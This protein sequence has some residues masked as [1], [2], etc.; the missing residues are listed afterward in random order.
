MPDAMRSRAGRYVAACA[1]TVALAVPAAGQTTIFNSNGYEPGAT[2]YTPGNVVGQRGFQGQP[3]SGTAGSIQTAT[4]ASG[5]QAFQIAGPALV[6][7]TTF[8]GGNFWF[9]PTDYNPV[10]SATPHVIV[11]FKSFTPAGIALPTDIPFAGVY[12]EGF[13]SFGLQQAVSPIMVNANGGVTVF[14]T[15]A[16]GGPNKAVSTASS[17]LPRGSWNELIADF[18]FATQTFRV[19]RNGDT[20]PLQFTTNGS[21]QPITP[22][23]DIPFRNGDANLTTDRVAEFGMLGFYGADTSGAPVQ[24]LN[25]FFIDDFSVTAS[26]TAF[27]PVPEPGLLLA[28]GA[29]GLTGWRTYRR[30]KAAIA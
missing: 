12:I 13:N 21:G 22:L 2:G 15:T 7:N 28:V 24:P 5:T 6:N 18:N 27:N 20:N 14:T 26:A 3:T 1:L 16:T 8:G 11:D 4:V 29:V 10:A 19:Y 30:R 25:N 9:Q 23:T 17:V